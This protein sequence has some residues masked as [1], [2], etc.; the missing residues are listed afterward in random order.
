MLWTTIDGRSWSITIGDKMAHIY[1]RDDNATYVS[2]VWSVGEEDWEGHGFIGKFDCIKEAKRACLEEIERANAQEEANKPKPSV[3]LRGRMHYSDY[4]E[5]H[6]TVNQAALS[7]YWAIIDNTFFPREI[8]A[9]G[10]VVWMSSMVTNDEY[11]TLKSL[12]GISDG[13]DEDE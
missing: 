10:K 2:G 5:D 6:Y 7:A 4:T 11:P 3:I 1:L 9:E 12:A 13:G 8:E